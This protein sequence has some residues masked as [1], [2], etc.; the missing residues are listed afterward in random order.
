MLKVTSSLFDPLGILSSV[1]VHM[2]VLFQSL[3]EKYVDWDVPLREEARKQW[4]KWLRDLQEVQEILIPRC[5]YEGVEEVVT[6]YSLH[7]FGDAFEKAYCAVVYLVIEASSG[8]FPVLLT[9][10]TR[11]APLSRQSIPRLELLSGVIL[12]RLASSVREAL[13]SQTKVDNTYLWFDSKTAICCIRGSKEWKQFVQNR[14]NEILSLSEKSMWNHCPRI[15]NPADI[16]SR[17]QFALNLRS[18][19]LWWKG[20]TWLSEPASSWLRSKDEPQPVTE[21]CRAELKKGAAGKVSDVSLLHT[22]D[23]RPDL[24]ACI[25]VT[26]FSC[27]DTLFRVT[28]PVLRFVRNLKIKAK[29]LQEGTVWQGEITEAEVANAETQWLR[30]V[31][32]NLKSQANYSQ[33]K[34]EFGLNEDDSGV[35]RCKGRIANADLP[36]ETKFSALL[37]RDHY[38]ATLMVRQAHERVHRNK[39]AA[40]LAQLRTRFWIIRG[41]QFVKKT[42]AGCTVCRRYEGRGYRVPPQADLPEFRLSQEPA[43]TGVGDDYAGPLYIKESN[44]SD[45]KKMYVLLFTCCSTRAVHLELATDLSADEFIRCLGRFTARKGIPDII[46]SDNAKT[47][48]SAAKILRKVLSYPN[49]KR[50]LAGRRIAWGFNVDRAPWWGGFF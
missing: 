44:R 47:F 2:K 43:F 25:L 34:H 31:Q 23:S 17:G 4:N 38:I 49:V 42:I 36:H 15:E 32:K 37:P 14:V 46:V 16:G 9:S 10:K 27:C 22:T 35:M 3:C 18:N 39:V 41:R 7:G 6:S 19:R 33:L 26:N 24:E 1:L 20:P 45:L 28:A 30:S 11:V 40:T 13:Q 12:T 5:V 50:F 8:Y 48:K 21:E 29:I